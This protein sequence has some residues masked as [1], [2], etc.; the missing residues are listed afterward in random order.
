MKNILMNAE[1]TK[2]V[3]GGRKTAFV[4]FKKRVKK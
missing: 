1:M 4:N 3:L 2:A